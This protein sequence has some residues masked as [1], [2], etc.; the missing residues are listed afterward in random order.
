MGTCR[1]CVVG[2]TGAV[3]Q[4]ML[5]VLERSDLSIA[6]LRLLASARSAGTELPFRG[7][8]ITV[9]EVTA[10]SFESM[11]YALFSAGAER[12]RTWAPVAVQAGAIVIDNSSA[13]RMQSDVPLVVP[14]IN[15]HTLEGHHG[16]IANPNCSTIQLVMA[17]QAIRDLYGLERVVV[18]TYQ[19][20]SGAGTRAMQ[21]LQAASRAVLD[22][23]KE[24]RAVHPRGIAFDCIPQIDVLEEDGW[25]REEIKMREE[26]RKI[27]EQQQLSV[28]ATCVRVPVLRCH[29][30]AVWVKTQ[31]PVVLADLVAAQE[32]QPGLQVDAAAQEYRTARQLSGRDEVHV[33]RLRLDPEDPCALSFWVVADNLLKGAALNAVQ[34]LQ[35]LHHQT[36]STP[37]AG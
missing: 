29:S 33:G 17:L 14:E 1:I 37:E 8:T 7:Q 20:V 32:Q 6:S 19:S 22:G 34:I 25:S 16:I 5:R 13:F 30:E 9:Q 21:E 18:A 23:N 27:L 4:E 36:A 10:E 15:P 11:D 2:A 31:T 35:Y 26:T 3:G 12:S 28:T 24:P